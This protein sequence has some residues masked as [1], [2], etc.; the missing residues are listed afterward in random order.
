MNQVELWA[1]MCTVML[2]SSLLQGTALLHAPWTSS[3]G[4]CTRARN[5]GTLSRR[6]RARLPHGVRLTDAANAHMH[7]GIYIGLWV[8]G[9]H[10]SL[11]EVEM[12]SPG[13]GARNSSRGCGVHAAAAVR[14]CAHQSEGRRGG[15]Y[16]CMCCRGRGRVYSLLETD[17]ASECSLGQQHGPSSIGRHPV[18]RSS[19]PL[20][21]SLPV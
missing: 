8:R 21:L 12:G 6:S 18:P 4:P 10:A 16:G 2:R 7:T 5:A 15:V 1:L 9:A 17:T 14:A 19:C 13:L 11:E 20:C 3:Q